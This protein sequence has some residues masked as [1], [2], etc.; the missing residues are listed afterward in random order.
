MAGQPSD[1]QRTS[2]APSS[3]SDVFD[4]RGARAV[5]RGAATKRLQENAYV[6]VRGDRRSLPAWVFPSILT[7][8]TLIRVLCVAVLVAAWQGWLLD[9]RFWATGSPVTAEHHTPFHGLPNLYGWRFGFQGFVSMH[10]ITGAGLLLVCLIPLFARKGGRTHAIFGRVFVGIWVLHLVNG[11]VNSAQIL[12]TRGLDPSRYLSTTG[13][14]FSLYLYL[15]F[16]FISALVIDFLAHGMAALHYKNKQPSRLVRA[17]MIALPVSSTLLGAA[18]AVWAVGHLAGTHTTDPSPIATEFAVVYL[19]QVPA[20][21]FLAAKNVSYWLLAEPRVWLQGWVTEHQRNLMFCVGVTLYTACANLTMRFAPSL[22]APLFASIDVGFVVW[23]LTK[24]RLLRRD[25][26]GAR[27]GIAVSAELAGVDRGAPR[28]IDPSDVAFVMRLFDENKNGF[29][30]VPEVERLLAAQG[31]SVARGEL[32]RLYRGVDRD[33]DGRIDRAELGELLSRCFA[34]EA[35]RDEELAY[36]FRRFDVD[37]DG[38]VSAEELRRAA[39]ETASPE[40]GALEAIAEGV[41]RR[42]GAALGFGTFASAVESK[43][44]P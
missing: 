33:R 16:A 8:F 36:A 40:V 19:V 17:L 23:L 29:L 44:S 39:R 31:I 43:R 42:Q 41:E 22:T 12:L 28:V 20:Y 30:D 15:Q 37:G 4:S 32:E 18:L 2:G 14:G 3:P 38:R 5:L 6:R 13:Q 11:L 7:C 35:R 10:A 27:L 24:E 9:P 21:V 26:V 1:K 25:I 34:G